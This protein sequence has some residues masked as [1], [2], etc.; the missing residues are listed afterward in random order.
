MSSQSAHSRW[1]S[2]EV[3]W[4][5]KHRPERMIPVYLEDCNLDD[6]G[7]AMN[8]YNYVDFRPG[9]DRGEANRN[10]LRR[11]KPPITM[12]AGA[13]NDELDLAEERKRHPEAIRRL[14]DSAIGLLDRYQLRKRELR[15]L[16]SCGMRGDDDQ[17]L[18]Q[19]LTAAYRSLPEANRRQLPALLH[20][21]AKLQ[22][23]AG[24]FGAALSDFHLVSEMV[25]TPTAQAEA[26]FNAYRT[27]LERRNWPEAQRSLEHAV[28]LDAARFAP[29]PTDAYKLERI[30]GSGAFGV[31]FLCHRPFMDDRVVIKALA[32]DGLGRGVDQVFQEAR[33]LKR[34][35]HSAIIE[36]IDGNYVDPV[37]KAR[38]FL[39]MEY[40]DG[41]TLE[42][43][44]EQ[45]GTMIPYDVTKVMRLVAEGLEEAHSEN[46][47]H[48]DLKPA[49][50][51]LRRDDDLWE[52][53][54]ID[55]GLALKQDALGAVS[56]VASKSAYGS[57]VAGTLDYAAPE[58]LGRLPGVPVGPP[59]DYY[60]LGKTCCHALFKKTHLTDKDWKSLRS[61][62][63]RKWLSSLLDEDPHKRWQKF[64][65]VPNLAKPKRKKAAVSVPEMDF[66]VCALEEE[67]AD[68]T[69]SLSSAASAVLQDR[70]AQRPSPPQA[71]VATTI[72][73]IVVRG[74]SLNAAFSLREG[75]NYIGRSKDGT[76]DIDLSAQDAPDNVSVSR[77]HAVLKVEA[78]KASIQDLD[79]TNGSYL[80]RQRLRPTVVYP[81]H[82]GD[83]IQLGRVQLKVRSG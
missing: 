65:K 20:A 42:E 81:L 62:T 79:S 46:I 63:F 38:P 33:L 26:H 50:I 75:S 47:V 23:L 25:R 44:V 45:N 76:A 37:A 1:V 56:Y 58:Q 83:V 24:Q 39:V 34:L 61:I 77:L 32:T 15:P 11:L 41:I 59:A 54:I 52:V 60:A 73:L 3:S 72:S 69:E 27:T 71:V 74:R 16:D 7:L 17:R 82:D 51:M 49:N 80:N 36:V 53:K 43:Y 6:F 55:F 30:L 64:P 22:V 9:S 29:F 12:G 14:A 35:N 48:R 57:S 70:L 13:T 66:E 19:Q 10:L 21:L 2:A 18:V 28:R 8:Q 67:A 4:A 31:V 68:E 40:F 78:G 5:F